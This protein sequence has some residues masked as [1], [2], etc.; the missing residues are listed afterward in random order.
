MLT[1]HSFINAVGGCGSL[2]IT[3]SGCKPRPTLM[4]VDASESLLY[5]MEPELQ[6][7]RTI[8][9]DGDERVGYYLEYTVSPRRAA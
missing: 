7:G 9:V 2:A 5:G 3:R 8:C 4:P 1:F 6:W